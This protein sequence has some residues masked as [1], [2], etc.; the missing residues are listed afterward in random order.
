MR[1]SIT[2]SIPEPCHEDWNKMTPRDKGRHCS[3]CSKTVIDFTNQ[4]DEQIV[5]TFEAKGNLCGRFKNQQLN[6]EIVSTR[7]DKNNYR[8]WIASGLFAFLSVGIQKSIAQTEPVKTTYND[9]LKV[10]TV[11]G[12]IAHSILNEKVISGTIVSAS[13]NLPLPGAN[14]IVKGTSRGIQTDFDGNFSI[15]AK[16]NEIL[17]F[18]YIG[19]ETKEIKITKTTNHKLSLVEMDEDIVGEIVVVGGA[20]GYNSEYVEPYLTTEEKK[21]RIEKRK[22]RNAKW[23]Q[24]NKQKRLKWKAERLTKKLKRKLKRKSKKQS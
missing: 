9:T 6:R 24:Q 23:K 7:K 10:P 14:V 4:S 16:I 15:K 5:K 11:K 12:K 2:V 20:F 19:F 17:I 22:K 18:S 13:D 1:K 21:E 8:N 3:K